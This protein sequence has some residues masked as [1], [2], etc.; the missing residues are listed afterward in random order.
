MVAQRDSRRAAPSGCVAINATGRHI[1]ST[2]RRTSGETLV[3]AE[4]EI[5]LGAI[6]G[7]ENLAVLIGTHGPRVD[8]EIRVELA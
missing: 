4:V 1:V 5:G 3:M 7:D 2:G 6:V 8:I